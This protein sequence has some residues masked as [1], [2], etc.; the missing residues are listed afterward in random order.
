MYK[1]PGAQKHYV[2]GVGSIAFLGSYC[3]DVEKFNN[4]DGM[5]DVMQ[6][7]YAGEIAAV[8]GGTETA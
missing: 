8:K 1:T 6:T 7:Y 5:A 2:V 4:I 3:I